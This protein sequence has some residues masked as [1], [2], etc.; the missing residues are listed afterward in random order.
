MDRLHASAPKDVDFTVPL[1][2]VAAGDLPR[3]GGKGA[4]LGEMVRAGL[5]VPPGFCVTT[6]AFRRF[7]AAVDDSAGIYTALA[8]LGPAD[9]EGVRRVGAEV[10]ARLLGTPVP[11]ELQAAIVTAWEAAGAAASY[12]V[13]SSA[14]AEDLPDASFAGQQDTYLHVRGRDAIVD[15]VRACWASL[16]TDRAILYRAQNGFDHRE[17]SLAVVVQEMV[18]PDVSG[19]LFTADP[20][21]GHRG[22]LTIDASYGLGEALVSG[23]VSA[24]L[25]KVDKRSGAIVS[26]QI[27]DKQLA[28][29]PL[30]G[31]GTERAPV[32]EEDRRKPALTEEAVRA[33]A[34]LG[35]RIEAHYGRPM[36]IEWC[37]A[38]GKLYVVQARPITSLYPLP[39]P[40]PEPRPGSGKGTGPGKGTGDDALHVY[41]SF[42]HA[43]VMTD[44]MSPMGI[45]L[46]R[47]LPPFGRDSAPLAANP[48]FT[49][50]GGRIY[51]DLSPLLRHPTLRR[52]VLGFLPNIDRLIA[53][54]VGEVCERDEFTRSAETAARADLRAV[55]ER[56]MPILARAQALLWLRW[57]EGTAE[58][59]LGRIDQYVA[60]LETDLMATAPGAPRLR[61]VGT[62]LGNVLSDAF[63]QFAYAIP[64]GLFAKVFLE[65]SLPPE[66]DPADVQALARGLNGNVTTEMDL[67]VGDLADAARQTPALAELLA[68]AD[69]ATALAHIATLPADNPFAA[70]WRAFLARYGMRGPSEIDV[71]RPRYRDAPGALLMLVRGNL[72]QGQA[73]AHRA[74]HQR[75]VVEGEAAA[76]RVIATVRRAPGGWLKARLV[77]RLIRVMRHVLPLREHPKYFLIR[78]FDLARRAVL[79]AAEQLVAQ[80]RL[81]STEDVW[82]L[83]LPEAIAALED[84]TIELRSTVRT[85]QADLAHFRRLK[86]PRVITSTGEIPVVRHEGAGVPTG[87]LP[88]TPVSAG[89]VEGVARVV[90][91]PQREALLPG[92]ILVAPFTDPGWT[93]LFIHAAGLVMEVGG[94]MTHGSVVAREYGIPAVVGVVDATHLIRTGQRVRVHGDRGYIELLD[95]AP[96]SSTG[97]QAAA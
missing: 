19:I 75:L 61:A 49:S 43:Q 96:S 7:L 34:A 24:D 45:S 76:E 5:P 67:A 25:Y 47:L 66:V 58:R 27:G 32:P 84:P 95:A 74:H 44:P 79:E 57:T 28:I 55:A 82:F 92:E 29:R 21:S 54:A 16:F 59:L 72:A 17:V 89:V 65:R 51:A 80:G 39:E 73:G 2:H 71:S 41:F 37:S 36:D 4:N 12:A 62:A 33:L 86:P 69:P 46:W 11:A 78:V 31:G 10:R 14:T 81:G 68:A 83:T 42:S 15:A 91:D 56:L 8:V 64:A 60:R 53:T 6:A 30:P 52:M 77:R 23:L 97:P 70:A 13:R 26:T 85:R 3:V 20:V 18:L 50:A 9:L 88:G 40:G 93:P 1:D 38:G 35:A 94:L 90:Q 48:Y 22:I 63:R 87:A